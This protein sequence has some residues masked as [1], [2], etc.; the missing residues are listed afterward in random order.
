[1]SKSKLLMI[2][3]MLILAVSA[4]SLAVSMSPAQNPQTPSGS[5]AMQVFSVI[6]LAAS[7]FI[8]LKL[9]WKKGKA[10]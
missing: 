9:Y 2:A 1:M 6:V 4:Y 10:R 3:A 8:V 5:Q 7:A